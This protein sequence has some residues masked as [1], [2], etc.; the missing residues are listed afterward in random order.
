[1]FFSERQNHHAAFRTDRVSFNYSDLIDSSQIE[2]AGIPLKKN[3]DWSAD[4]C[5]LK[6][7]ILSWENG[8]FYYLSLYLLRV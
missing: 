8:A 7:A 1:M 6:F 2:K 3:V 5:R 4:W